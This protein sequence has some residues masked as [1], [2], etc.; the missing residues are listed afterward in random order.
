MIKRFI[1][2]TVLLIVSVNAYAQI[3]GTAMGGIATVTSEG[4]IDTTRNPALLGTHHTP[5]AAFYSLGTL[6]YTDDAKLKLNTPA[7]DIYSIRAD[8]D[9]FYSFSLF[10]GIA[11]PTG[12]GTIGYSLSSKDNLYSRRKDTQTIKGS[13]SGTPF[14]QTETTITNEFNPKLSVAYGW[15]INGNNF[16]GIQLELVPFYSHKKT[17]NKNTLSSGYSYS[18][19]E[20][21]VMIE[22][23]IG[24]LILE[25]DNQ[26]GLRLSPAL[27]KCVKK[28]AE[29]DFSTIDKTYNDTWDIQ[30]SEGPKIT[31]GGYAKIAPAIGIALEI[32]L[33]FP[34]SYT[35][36]DINITNNPAPSIQ[37]S[38]ITIHNDST[39]AIKGGLH[40][41]LSQSL[42]CMG[43]IAYF[44][45]TN[46]SGNNHNNGRGTYNLL[47]ISAGSNYSLSSTSILTIMLIVTNASF[48]SHYNSENGISLDANIASDSWN[49]TIGAGISYRL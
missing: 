47:L 28:K 38:S 35:N 31:A 1:L 40:F 14:E 33:M 44:H 29:A 10:A 11:K 21:G 25:N 12:N 18:I 39:V 34:S 42:E 13:I 15:N 45:I 17:E 30:Q 24:F 48:E 27:V 41:L 8:N 43:G 46:T 4:A 9:Y 19:Q 5:M 23:A 26:V 7:I 36:T 20:Y 3:I 22:P 32:G 16:A 37:H 49:Y 6:F 2:V